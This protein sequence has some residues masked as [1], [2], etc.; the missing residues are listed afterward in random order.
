MAGHAPSNA[1]STVTQPVVLVNNSRWFGGAE[2][3]LEHLI[4]AYSSR[5]PVVLATRETAPPRLIDTAV[6][7]GVPVMLWRPTPSGLLQ[8][9]RQLR[10]ARIV[11]LNMAWLGDNAHAIALSW[12]CRRPV[13]ATVH[14]WMQPRSDMRR[15]ILTI[16]YRRFQHVI[17]VSGEIAGLLV[18]ELGV[19]RHLV[20]IVPNGVAE[21]D[22]L[23][24]P[25]RP[26]A[27]IGALGRLTWAKGFDLL[28]EAVRRVHDRGYRVEAVI[29]GEGGERGA[30]EAAAHGLPVRFVG[31][32]EDVEGF[33]DEIDIF[34]LPSR[35][36]GLPFALLEAMM[37]GAA[38]VAADVGDV[39]VALD[40]TGV[41]VP[42]DDIDA[43]TAALEEL[44]SLPSLRAELGD[45][46]HSRAVRHFGME[47]FV[48]R[49]LAV[50]ATVEGVSR[51]ASR[52]RPVDAGSGA[53]ATA[54]ARRLPTP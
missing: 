18:S 46:C 30:L 16:G 43:L 51:R 10:R 20:T 22:P 15:R 39:A 3:Y 4:R 47:T 27:R 9:Y 38:C 2:V 45:A 14:I 21:R 26:T 31:F 12:L 5:V 29:G 48:T 41:V 32:V 49:T 8:L 35:R 7:A 52:R 54:G 44:G 19:P 17:A 1:L 36:E 53:A 37:A 33:L 13:V 50:Y 42:P 24:R 23:P 34:C 40:S 11:H 28:V 25:S 6:R